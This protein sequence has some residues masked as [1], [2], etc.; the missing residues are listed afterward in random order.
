MLDYDL[1]AV[2]YDATRGGEPRARAAADALLPLVP[3]TARTLLD[4]ACGTGIVT[5]RLTRP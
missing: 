1:E 4:L 2:R 3:G 5:R